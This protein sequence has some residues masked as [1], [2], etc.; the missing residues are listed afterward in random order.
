MQIDKTKIS[1]IQFMFTIACF[2]QSSSLLT[3]FFTS[4]T[5]QDSWIVVI[6]G[7]IF[8]IP[9]LLIYTY[10]MKK[11][12]DKNLME[13]NEIV[14]GTVIGKVF[15]VL[16]LWFFLTLASLNTRDL[17]DFVQKTTM[18]NTPPIIILGVFIL[19][20][21]WAV[22]NG[23]KSV[24][25]YS[26][27]FTIVAISIMISTIFLTMSQMKLDNF[28]PV[29]QQ[30]KMVYI[31]GSH[32][33][34]AIPFGE[35]I[36]FLMLNGN[37]EIEAGKRRKYFIYGFIIGGL[38]LLAIVFRDTA[39]LGNTLKMFSLPPFETL[40]LIRIHP[41]LSRVEVLFAVSLIML[42]F[43]KICILYYVTVMSIAYIVKLKSFQSLVAS[44]GVIIVIY[45]FFIYPSII[46]HINSAVKTVPFE[47]FVFE[48]LLPL[49]TAIVIKIRRLPKLKKGAA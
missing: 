11:F 39:V 13:I 26:M 10:I 24:T 25:R 35:V 38:T 5:K 12:P 33:I 30:P 17:G 4:I 32:V 27:F 47:W 22:R 37:I 9:S 16:Y 1:G 34:S 43:F 7:F 29:F 31:Q 49:I 48:T 41:A 46:E 36:V 3:S 42:M 6:L 19:L 21:S 20:C 18:E 15:S 2:I 40:R 8:S 44:V 28:L 45:S 14:F 23:V